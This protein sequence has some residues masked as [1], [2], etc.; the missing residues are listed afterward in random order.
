[1]K[2]IVFCI[3]LLTLFLGCGTQIQ[4]IGKKAPP[5][6]PEF[7][8]KL[9]PGESIVEVKGV[10]ANRTQAIND[11]RRAAVA[12]A[13][14]VKVKSE[15]MVKNFELKKDV[16][17]AQTEG[18]VKNYRIIS[19]TP[20]PDRY[21][22]IIQAVVSLATFEPDIK[23]ITEM[24]GDM[25]IL[26]FYDKRDAKTQEDKV[27]YEYAY[28]RVNE[29]LS[30]NGYDY[31]E[32]DIF[33]R[34]REEVLSK[35]PNLSGDSLARELTRRAG[36]NYWIRFRVN[37]TTVAGID[38]AYLEL[39]AHENET[40]FGLGV[41]ESEPMLGGGVDERIERLKN[42]VANSVP[43]GM[44]LLM[45]QVDSKV[46]GWALN[47]I[48]YFACIYNLQSAEAWDDLIVKL[49]DDPR[50]GGKLV[51][52]LNM[53]NHYGDMYFTFKGTPDECRR[54]LRKHAK[55]IPAFSAIKVRSSTYGRIELTL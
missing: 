30:K 32:H 36:A 53:D 25:I 43:G 17:T 34:R 15:T 35:N 10:G 8:S 3:M 14:G 24:I 16:I 39:K 4:R 40:G 26:V 12:Q 33:Q 23:M 46:S 37:K 11:A 13:V 21:E 19:E 1:M 18:L 47:G 45:S 31:V 52:H 28:D 48:K 9:G 7:T 51:D 6:P 42:A 2:R 55:S 41:Q 27:L 54:Y 44:K 22:V 50:F 38:A 29:Y 20:F 49:K 5:P